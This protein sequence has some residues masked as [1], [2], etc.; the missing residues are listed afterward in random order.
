[1]LKTTMITLLVILV[2]I[3]AN[4]QDSTQHSLTD[5]ERAFEISGLLISREFTDVGTLEAGSKYG[6]KC[7][8]KTLRLYNYETETVGFVLRFGMEGT[9]A[10]KNGLASIEL[11]EVKGLIHALE[12]IKADIIN[13]S[14]TTYTEVYYKSETG[15]KIGFYYSLGKIESG[16]SRNV[17][18]YIETSDATYEGKTVQKDDKGTF[19]WEMVS[20]GGSQSGNWTF[21]IDTDEVGTRAHYFPVASLEQLIMLIEN[22]KK[23]MTK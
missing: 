16:S 8:I 5:T 20:T 7:V 9:D 12:K 13:T 3:I 14:P 19:I 10:R 11:D 4:G 15:L 21:F 17:K 6:D 23:L 18:K 1:M 2:T 22:G